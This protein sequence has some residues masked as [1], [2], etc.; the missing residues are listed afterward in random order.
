MLRL[1]L[2]VAGIRVLLALLAAFSLAAQSTNA[3]SPEFFENKVRP[4]LATSCYA[5]HTDSALGGLRLDSLE[6]M[7]K[8]G[9]RGTALVPGSP[10][11]SLLISAIKQTDPKLKMPMGG[12]L[13]DQEIA[14]LEA[15]VKAGAVW[16]K[17]AAAPV[18]STPGKYVISP[19]RRAFW[20]LQPL[21]NPAVP[22]ARDARW[23]KTDID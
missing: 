14:D 5:C 15:W 9:K 23:A 12:K 22:T 3:G 17:S 13:K 10:E 18:S 1:N 2:T 19:E 4:V 21:Q 20:S 6:A 11:Q 8:G 16:P 7:T